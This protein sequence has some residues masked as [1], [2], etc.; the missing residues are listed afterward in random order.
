[1]SRAKIFPPTTQRGEGRIP[2]ELHTSQS[3]SCEDVSCDSG[4]TTM[5]QRISDV[6]VARM[7][8]AKVA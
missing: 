6:I 4:W 2:P 1:M 8:Q 7:S 3:P 5:G